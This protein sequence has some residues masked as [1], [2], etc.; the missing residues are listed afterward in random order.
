MTSSDKA[1]LELD[2][3]SIVVLLSTE[4]ARDYKVPQTTGGGD[5]HD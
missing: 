4:G 2:K 1:A 5:A 3:S